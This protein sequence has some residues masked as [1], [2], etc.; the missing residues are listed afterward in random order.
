MR[1]ALT[2][3]SVICGRDRASVAVLARSSRAIAGAGRP[4]GDGRR[5]EPPRAGGGGLR[6]RR[7]GDDRRQ[8]RG[9][10][11]ARAGRRA[12]ADRPSPRRQPAAAL[13]PPRLVRGRRRGRRR[14]HLLGHAEAADAPVPGSTSAARSPRRAPPTRRAPTRSSS[15][16]S[17]PAATCAGRS[18][19]GAARAGPGRAARRLPAAARR[20]DRRA[21]PMSRRALEAGAEGAVAGTRFLLSEESRAHPDY[22]QR[23]LAAEAT[24]LTE[25]FGTGWPAPHRVIA[26]AATERWLSRRRPAR[27]V[28]Q[29]RPEPPQRPGRPLHAAVAPSPPGP[30][31]A[32]ASRLLTPQ[33][34]TDDGPATLVDAGP[35]Y[36]GQTVARDRRR[37]P[38]GRD[39]PR[40]D[41]LAGRG[42]EHGDV[43]QR[44]FAVR[45]LGVA[46]R[47]AAA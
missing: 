47:V 38:G 23:L 15:R 7:A 44:E 43:L 2:R 37:Q 17:R 31:P 36:A 5:A 12:G 21:R 42:R 14:R 16:A 24:I 11:P 4:G 41:P 25:L 33:G 6:G 35:L 1:K 8:R 46:E 34:P 27:A 13:R 10:D 18:G 9:G 19:A 30:L 3:A 20:W 28:A 29:P 45:V 26:N 32:P 39:R 40:P 22:R